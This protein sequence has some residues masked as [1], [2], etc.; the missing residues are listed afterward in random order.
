MCSSDLEYMESVGWVE[1]GNSWFAHCVYIN[2]AEA[3]RMGHTHTG[4]A[5]CP[6]SNLRLGSGIAP[7]PM[8]L[9]HNVPVGLGV[10]GSA[11][12]DSSDMLGEARQCMLVHRLENVKAMP[13]RKAWNWPPAAAPPC[14]GAP[15]SAPS[16][17]AKPPTSPSST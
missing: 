2:E 9:R 7:I 14:W 17:P 8:F 15:T 6:C 3:K 16:S 4:V 13:A 1:E 11:S 10:D 12:N 5:H